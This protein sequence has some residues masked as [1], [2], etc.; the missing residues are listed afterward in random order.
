MYQ[1]FFNT[2]NTRE[3]STEAAVFGCNVLRA[4]VLSFL[5]PLVADVKNAD[6]AVA[7]GRVAWG[8]CLDRYK[9]YCKQDPQRRV[10]VPITIK[11]FFHALDLRCPSLLG[12]VAYMVPNADWCPLLWTHAEQ[13]ISISD[14]NCLDIVLGKALRQ[15]EKAKEK[16]NRSSSVVQLTYELFLSKSFQMMYQTKYYDNN[17]FDVLFDQIWMHNT[18]MMFAVFENGIEELIAHALFTN[19]DMLRILLHK[20]VQLHASDVEAAVYA[21]NSGVLGVLR[22]FQLLNA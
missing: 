11:S 4:L 21:N 22:E 17:L 6:H 3:A 12:Y 8:A 14:A 2:N 20:Q 9:K 1:G 13:I 18:D 5:S 7:L 19:S 16:E 10:F 15:Y